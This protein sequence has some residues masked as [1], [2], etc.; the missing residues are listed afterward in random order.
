M[1]K[2]IVIFSILT[3]FNLSAQNKIAF[4]KLVKDTAGI[5]TLNETP[6]T[7][8]SL[9]LWPSNNKPMQRVEWQVGRISGTF[10]SWYEDGKQDQIVGYKEGVRDG[11]FKTFY[12]N[13]APEVHCKYIMM[14]SLLPIASCHPEKCVALHWPTVAPPRSWVLTAS[15]LSIDATLC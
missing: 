11:E 14:M 4:S 3:A 12:T 2:Y 7:G 8:E 6:Y 15:T 5:Y 9:I 13:G 1:R 10:E